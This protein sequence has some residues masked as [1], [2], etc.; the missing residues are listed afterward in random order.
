MTSI[1]T[2]CDKCSSKPDKINRVL[3]VAGFGNNKIEFSDNFMLPTELPVELNDKLS[4]LAEAPS[5]PIDAIPIVNE[6]GMSVVS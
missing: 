5:V 1:F 4:I 2:P 3:S 6:S